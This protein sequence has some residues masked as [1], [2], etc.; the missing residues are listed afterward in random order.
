VP[1]IRLNGHCSNAIVKIEIAKNV[2]DYKDGQKRWANLEAKHK[3][4][5]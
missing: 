4:K 1:I 5:E 3:P 2:R